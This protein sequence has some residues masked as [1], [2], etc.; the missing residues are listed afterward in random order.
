MAVIRIA[1]RD[2]VP[3][4]L[5]WPDASFGEIVPYSA[6]WLGKPEVLGRAELRWRLWERLSGALQED[7]AD[8][9]HEADLFQ[10]ALNV[11]IGKLAEVLLQ[12]LPS[13]ERDPLFINDI[14]PRLGALI[15]MPGRGGALAR[16]RLAA[17]L[18]FMFDRA[19]D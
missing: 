6:E 12:L 11:P 15:E 5:A 3:S 10:K 19:P 4:S 1:S 16:T 13:S 17:E 9:I 8:E 18:S 14:A 2:H 7:D